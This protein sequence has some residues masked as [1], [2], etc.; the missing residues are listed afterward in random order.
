MIS[1][2]TQTS[3]A[4]KWLPDLASNINVFHSKKGNPLEYDFEFGLITSKNWG[5][6]SEMNVNDPVITILID[7]KDYEMKLSKFKRIFLENI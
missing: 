4:T 5:D 3:K 7:K 6:F 1:V 2:K